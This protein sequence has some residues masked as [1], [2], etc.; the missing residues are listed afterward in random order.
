MY[1]EKILKSLQ[2]ARSLIQAGNPGLALHDLEKSVQKF[3]R[4]FEAWF[5][6]GHAKGMLNDHVYAETCFKKAAAIQPKNPVV[7][8]NH[9]IGYSVRSMHQEA[10]PC[11]ERSI[12]YSGQRKIEAYHNLGS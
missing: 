6:L 12:A 3:P 11:F 1:P 5:L 8:F 7:W 2:R 9:G 10:I 4:G